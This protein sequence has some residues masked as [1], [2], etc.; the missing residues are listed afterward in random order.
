MNI[1]NRVE[2]LFEEMVALRRNIHKEPELGFD[3]VKTISKVKN[4]LKRHSISYDENLKTGVVSL[5]KGKNEGPTVAIRADMDALP[6]TEETGLDFSST[7]K[8]KMHACG[9]D[10][11]TTCLIGAAIILNEMKE[12]LSGNVKLIFQPA[13]ETSGGAVPMIEEGVMENPTV[14]YITAIHLMPYMETGK[15]EIKKGTMNASSD[16]I[17]IEVLGKSS[18]GAYPD[19]GVDAIVVASQLVISLQQIVSRSVSPFDEV[20]LSF[21]TINGGVASNVIADKVTLKGTLR[22]LNEDVRV[23]V[24]EKILLISE[25][26]GAAFGARVNVTIQEGYCV[27][28]NDSQVVDTVIEVAKDLFGSDNILIKEKSSLGVDD[29][30]F[31]LHH[32]KGAYYNIGC[33]FKNKDMPPLHSSCFI[34]DEECIKTG[35][36]M[37]VY[38]TIKLLNR[39]K[40]WR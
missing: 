22:T 31:F 34:A 36:L 6:L 18:H 40:Q 19:E 7:I 32:A 28:N 20:V 27:L 5:I 14:D 11:H 25:S 10:I 16:T 29:F 33:G 15:V 23:R 38:S 9:H 12:E 21:G 3:L 26:V 4:V 2:E 1:K 39:N 13:E 37:H 24:K 35:I 30:A 17:T 8:G